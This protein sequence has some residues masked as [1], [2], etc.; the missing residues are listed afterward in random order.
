MGRMGNHRDALGR[1]PAHEALEAACLGIQ[2]KVRLIA[3]FVGDRDSLASIPFY[4]SMETTSYPIVIPITTVFVAAR[5]QPY[6]SFLAA[7]SDKG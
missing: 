7:A 4:Y 1:G 2:Q 3:R 6:R 5:T